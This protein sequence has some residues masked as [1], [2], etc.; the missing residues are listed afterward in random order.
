MAPETEKVVDL[1]PQERRSLEAKKKASSSCFFSSSSSSSPILPRT[2]CPAASRPAS[3]SFAEEGSRE[4][5]REAVHQSMN[6]AQIA[7]QAEKETE[8][9]DFGNERISSNLD[10][11]TNDPFRDIGANL[12]DRMKDFNVANLG[13][14]ISLSKLGS[15]EFGADMRNGIDIGGGLASIEK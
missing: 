10:T 14:E 1:A 12:E 3:S 13:S 11:E 8:A 5:E 6:T 9:E 15:R 2:S 7:D 4:A